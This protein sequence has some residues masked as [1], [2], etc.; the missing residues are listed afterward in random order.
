VSVKVRGEAPDGALV[1][2]LAGE[3]HAP[4]VQVVHHRHVVLPAAARRLV[5]P[6]AADVVEVRRRACLVDVMAQHAPQRIIA[7]AEDARD[8]ENGHLPGEGDGKGLEH[9]REPRPLSCPRHRYL[10][11][12]AARATARARDLAVHERLVLEEC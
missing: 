3:D 2:S 9:Q 11:R 5:D 6:D 4:G 1:P 7:D 8:R 12:L 10:Q